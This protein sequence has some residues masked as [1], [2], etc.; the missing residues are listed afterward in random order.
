MSVEAA[1]DRGVAEPRSRSLAWRA[2]GTIV[3]PRAVYA[4]VAARPRVLGALL[5]IMVLTAAPGFVFM[6][7]DLGKDALLDQQARVMESFGAELTDEMYAQLESRLEYAPYFALAGQITLPLLAA[8]AAGLIMA[9][10]T[11]LM[12]GD[13]TFK[14]V[15]AIVVHSGFVIALAGVFSLPLNF[16]RGSLTAVATLSVFA[17]FLDDSSFPARLLGLIDLFYVWWVVNLAIGIGVLFKRRTGPIATSFL[18]L[19]AVIALVV[20][21]VMAAFSRA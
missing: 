1:L 5:L 12:G 17:P 8:V 6:S 20:A 15:Y 7:T 9:V 3:S 18:L 2:V 4:D 16:A 14:Q 21:G 13:A 19:Y 10:F 11:A